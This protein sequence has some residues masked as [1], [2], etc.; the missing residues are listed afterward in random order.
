MNKKV[1]LA[2]TSLEEFWDKQS[3]KILFL[4]EWCK[5]NQ[6]NYKD[7]NFETLE[8][9]WGQE[10][11]I[12]LGI[13]YG[14]DTYD[15]VIN[16]LVHILNSYHETNNSLKYWDLLLRPWLSIYIQVL[17]D[18]YRHIQFAKDKYKNLYT[19]ILDKED[20]DF[21]N[22]PSTFSQNIVNN[23]KY[24]LQLY[25]EIIR[26]MDIE[27]STKKYGKNKLS[28]LINYKS[29]FKN[30]L[31]GNLTKLCNKLFNKN[32]I[33][34]VSPYFKVN[35]FIKYSL[36]SF[37]SNFLFV[38]NNLQYNI[39]I[40]KQPDLQKRKQL[41]GDNPVNDFENILIST[42]VNNFPMIY[43]EGYKEFNNNVKNLNIGYFDAIYSSNAIYNNEIFKFYCADCIG[44]TKLLYG[45]HG[46]NFGIDKKH[47]LERIEKKFADKYFTFGWEENKNG[48]LPSPYSEITSSKNDNINFIMTSMPRYFYRFVY[49]EDSSKMLQY[50][51]N[52][53]CFFKEVD[54]VENIII[55]LYMHDYGW[56]IQ[57]KLLSTNL[58]LQFDNSTD[59]YEQI[60]NAKLNIFDHL[61]T[62]YLETMSI[63]KPTI[64]LIT[65]NIY[66]F[67]DEVKN[68][69][70]KLKNVN[71]L[72]DNSKE[73]AIFL[74]QIDDI[75][76]WWHSNE[77]Q[78]VRKEFCNKY[79][80]T[81]KNWA[82]EWIE[83]FNKVLNGK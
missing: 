3:S 71:I 42:F 47:V 6:H 40:N 34:I 56:N 78:N 4:G 72:F 25:S 39:N 70:E 63:N 10:K 77:V 13:E 30:T 35:K 50:I 74:N 16:K 2:T 5:I 83:E 32:K 52:A 81:S 27:Y 80:R 49:Q 66:F 68:D 76:K 67:R 15:I 64:V 29:N 79:I 9:I 75:N 69:I 41:F 8:Y 58:N 7:L 48:V 45:Q 22:L 24:N 62:G 54:K 57:E 1:F 20:F 73:A 59:Y 26:F 61:H 28:F 65:K 11:E 19:V 31:V 21:I 18:K 51:E 53:K 33:L 23:E 38:F 60:I 37:K 82:E 55:R 17:Y 12:D 43:L 46:G 36:L 44:K 14:D